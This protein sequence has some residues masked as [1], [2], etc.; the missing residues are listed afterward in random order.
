MSIRWLGAV[1]VVAATIAGCECLPEDVPCDSPTRGTGLD[2]E[3]CVTG[4]TYTIG[5]D[6]IPIL[7][8]MEGANGGPCTALEVGTAV[9]RPIYQGAPRNDW[10]PK[11]QVWL[12]PYY[13]DTFE[14]TNGRY[15]EC[16]T[17]G[18]CPHAGGV[19]L[20]N[21]SS[22][23][24][25]VVL[26]TWRE[27]NDYC[28]WRGK[29]LPTEAEWEAAG[30]GK[31]AYQWPWG[32]EPRP[33]RGAFPPYPSPPVG[34]E[35]F[36]VSPFGVHDLHAGVSEWVSDWYG[37]PYPDDGRVQKNP[38]G[39]SEPQVGFIKCCKSDE[40]RRMFSWDADKV[41]RGWTASVVGGYELNQLD[42]DYPLWIRNNL[43]AA[44][45]GRAED[46]WEILGFR[47]ARGG[48]TTSSAQALEST[49][50]H[51]NLTWQWYDKR[52]SR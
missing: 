34:T 2:E 20:D 13:I 37:G 35:A 22:A 24:S 8:I 50:T 21:P 28:Q 18:A 3:R 14:V 4:G 33:R 7:P 39:P 10:A 15:K 36:D 32:N 45:A 9:C 31:Q 30:R 46:A 6:A 23:D 41:V 16:V 27:A 26:V 17:A 40:W 1:A 42:Y 29:R 44:I 11:H 12:S 43:D 48:T 51:R 19:E 52:G 5:A 47:C 49:P 38:Q 25:P